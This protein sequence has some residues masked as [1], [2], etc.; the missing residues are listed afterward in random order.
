MKTAAHPL[1]LRGLGLQAGNFRLADIS[2]DV[3]AGDYLVLLGPTGAGKTV[4]VEAICGLRRPEAGRILIGGQDV[5]GLDPA[6]R[7][8]GY[9][10]QDYAL[11]PFLTV[12]GNIAFG[13]RA[14]KTPPADT[15]RRV[16]EMLALFGLTALEQRFPAHLSGGEKQRVALARALAV[17][18]DLLIMDEPLSALDEQTA[19]RLMRE[20]RRR[21]RQHR[22]TTIHICHRLEEA[23]Y[24]GERIALLRA[25][26]L[27]GAG[28]PKTFLERPRDL[29]SAQFFRLPNLLRG[30]I[31]PGAGGHFFYL[32]E[33]PVRPAEPPAGPAWALLPPE[34]L[35]LR[36][37]PGGDEDPRRVTL[38]LTVRPNHPARRGS[39]LCLGR[40]ALTLTIPGIF[41]P[42]QWPPGRRAWVEIARQDIHLLNGDGRPAA[43]RPRRRR[44]P[45]GAAG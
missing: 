42:E 18:P 19:N 24:L 30:R 16:A 39:E 3:A 14:R 17:E 44:K 9:L 32:G 22:R 26:R 29:F 27:V 43:R 33:T 23:L 45:G 15:A 34:R 4:L 12:G 7:R 25:G 10:P 28:R 37:E 2:L 8:I 35:T 11:L 5:S 1:A 38:A 6:R 13:L 41:P 21:H 36:R 40:G 20:I 31:A